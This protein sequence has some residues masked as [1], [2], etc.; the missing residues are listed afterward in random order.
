LACANAIKTCY[1]F[2]GEQSP[3]SL[4][5]LPGHGQ[6][7]R[8]RRPVRIVAKAFSAGGVVVSGAVNRQPQLFDA[9]ILTNAFLNVYATLMDP[10]LP[11]TQHEW[12]E[13]GN[14]YQSAAAAAA[15]QSFCPVASIP[16]TISKP[17][18]Q[19]DGENNTAS[20]PRFLLIA[21]LNDSQVPFYNNTLVYGNKLRE[22]T[23][24][25][26][27]IH[28]E[29]NGGHELDHNREHIAAIEAC[30]MSHLATT[31]ATNHG[32]QSH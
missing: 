4:S 14:P 22:K 31:A 28:I 12:D 10:A 1:S 3:S 18:D 32:S 21:V 29:P 9:V 30:F 19:Q 5:C 25:N 6:Q 8:R 15:I 27:I 16:S 2:T 11:L 13:Y 23:H 26:V 20:W 24:A 17:Q 7:Q